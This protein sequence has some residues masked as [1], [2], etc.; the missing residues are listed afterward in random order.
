MSRPTKLLLAFAAGAAVGSAILRRRLR[1]AVG[2]RM[3]Q[4]QDQMDQLKAA[5]E[6]Q[7]RMRRDFTA[8]VSHELKT[9]LTSISGYA[10]II[11]EGMVRSED[12]SRFAGKIYE[13]AQRLMTLV[14]DILNLSH[15]DEGAPGQERCQGIDLYALCQRALV[16]LDEAARQRAITLTLT[17]GHHTVDGAEKLLSE[18]IFNLCDNAIKYNE[19]GG[20]V[21]VSVTR[22]D[23]FVVLPVQDA[24]ETDRVFERFY[25]VDKS[26]SKKIGGTGLGLS[27]VKHAAAYH[28]ARI[29]LDSQLGH[30]TRVRV[31]FPPSQEGEEG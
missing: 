20:A 2:Q 29:Q 30:G 21:K 18:I 25:R 15:L 22:E 3:D 6:Q 24:G 19:D 13:E 27:I 8:N 16:S 28:D 4:V 12:V 17:G 11:R 26:H 31:L 23:G 14:E 1:P 5:Y 7:D 9:P 10:E